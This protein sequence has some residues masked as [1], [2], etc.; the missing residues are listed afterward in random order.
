VNG[1]AS[2]AMA[3]T[4]HAREGHM[5]SASATGGALAKRAK[6]GVSGKRRHGGV[7]GCANGSSCFVDGYC[8]DTKSGVVAACAST[9]DR[10]AFES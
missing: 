8:M 5:M 10:L 4:W 9:R 6:G 1:E 7:P 3:P 2:S